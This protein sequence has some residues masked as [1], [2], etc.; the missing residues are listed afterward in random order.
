LTRCALVIGPGDLAALAQALAGAEIAQE[1]FGID[2]RDHGVQ[3]RHVG[4]REAVLVAHREGRRH[5][6]R[7]ADAGRLDQQVVEAP[8]AASGVTSSQQVVAQGAA[9][10][11]V[12]E[13]DQRLLGA[14]QLRRRRRGSAGRRC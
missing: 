4:Q 11:A 9:D 10:A 13:L 8:L 12:A 1:G 3:P 5:R 14:R 6:H 2:H 7:L